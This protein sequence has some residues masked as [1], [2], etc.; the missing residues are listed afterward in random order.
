MVDWNSPE[1]VLSSADAL[2]KVGNVFFGL[3]VWE[4]LSS[5]HFDWEILVG[6]RKFKWPMAVYFICRYSM[7][8]SQV[9]GIVG[10]D[11]VT[12]VNCQALLKFA[13]ITADIAVTM[14]SMNLAIRTAAVWNN[15]L[16][17]VIP[18]IILNLSQWSIILQGGVVM[19][20]WNPQVS[21][22]SFGVADHT[23]QLLL[24]VLTMA[25]DLAVLVLSYYKLSDGLLTSPT[26][27]LL[28]HDG[29]LYFFVMFTV[30]VI[31]TTLICLDWNA[32][33]LIATTVPAT[34]VCVIASSQLVRRLYTKGPYAPQSIVDAF[35]VQNLSS[36]H[37][38]SKPS[39]ILRIE[40]ST[41][42]GSSAS[43]PSDV[44]SC[45]SKGYGLSNYFS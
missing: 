34:V 44:E 4:F 22:C 12:P 20:S 28:L 29:L 40:H 31:T 25:I 2:S 10:L 36:S 18:L 42:T 13:E 17:I 32:P 39:P 11:S 43:S 8:A 9:V 26:S 23:K 19:G 27:R 38:E 45:R 35:C 1:N 30:N 3:Y 24:V 16:R 15:E 7:L 6:K 5:L 21:S 14:A 33:I 37:T 41:Q